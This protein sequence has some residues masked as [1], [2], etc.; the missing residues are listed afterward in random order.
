[1]FYAYS[2]STG[3]DPARAAALDGRA[4]ASLDEDENDT[5]PRLSLI[6]I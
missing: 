2:P 4:R 6:H 5:A 1:M 3:Y